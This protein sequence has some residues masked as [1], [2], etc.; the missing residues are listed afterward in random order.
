MARIPS[1]QG[2]RVTQSITVRFE[3][4]LLQQIEQQCRAE[5]LALH[6][7]DHPNQS[8]SP[9]TPYKEFIQSREGSVHLELIDRMFYVQNSDMG[10]K[11]A[12]YAKPVT[13][14]ELNL[15]TSRVQTKRY[16]TRGT[17]KRFEARVHSAT[18]YRKY[19]NWWLNN[20]FAQGLGAERR[21]L[22][23]FEA[24]SPPPPTESYITIGE[25]FEEWTGYSIPH[26]LWAELS[27]REAQRLAPLKL[28]A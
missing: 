13:I 5:W 25:H 10:R 6:R 12:S 8:A 2:L 15:I 20:I 18:E 27:Q 7:I 21:E 4:H 1:I 14:N 23:P 19:R 26:E 17:R 3:D 22:C 11:P 16:N 28:A 24:Y 9:F